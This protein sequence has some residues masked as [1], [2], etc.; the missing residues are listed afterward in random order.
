[1]KHIFMNT[2]AY[3]SCMCVA[4]LLAKTQKKKRNNERERVRMRW[5]RVIL[6][7]VSFSLCI[8]MYVCMCYCCC[9]K[10]H[11][12][13]HWYQSWMICRQVLLT[14]R[15]L[16]SR[17]KTLSLPL[18]LA[19]AKCTLLY[20]RAASSESIRFNKWMHMC[21]F[22]ARVINFVYNPTAHPPT[23]PSVRRQTQQQD[24]THMKCKDLSI[25]CQ[26]RY[27]FICLYSLTS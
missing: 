9:W 26:F 16:P 7:I 1:M 27:T 8:Y 23:H 5:V 25:V 22:Y 20:I 11:L 10:A 6:V 14:Y 2:Q 3:Y 4:F 15:V 19:L 17:Y 18:S 12:R 13:S 21:Y 24:K